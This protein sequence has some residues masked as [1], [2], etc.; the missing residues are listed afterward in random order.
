MQPN[1]PKYT[2][3]Q[4]KTYLPALQSLAGKTVQIARAVLVEGKKPIDVANAIGES[5]Q[6]VHAAVKRV[7]GVLERETQ[8]LVPVLVW[9]TPDEAEEVKRM[10]AKHEKAEKRQ[11][12]D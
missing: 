7:N 5:R 2:P 1:Q 10:A 9:L 8:G 12:K 6:N 11:I 3:E 4:W